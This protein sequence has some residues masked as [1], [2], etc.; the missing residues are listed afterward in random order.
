MLRFFFSLPSR[1]CNEPTRNAKIIQP[2][3]ATTQ[4][5]VIIPTVTKQYTAA[6]RNPT[7]VPD[8]RDSCEREPYLKRGGEQAYGRVIVI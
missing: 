8:I 4:V 6:G 1:F 3:P 7:W 2:R 5:N